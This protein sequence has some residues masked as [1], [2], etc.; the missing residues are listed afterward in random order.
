[1]DPQTGRAA[2]T[3]AIAIT[4]PSAIML[5]FQ[6]PG[7]VEFVVTAMALAVGLLFLGVVI[8]FVRRAIR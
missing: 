6:E 1:M 8:F 7:S 3:L 2:F 5:L 4:V